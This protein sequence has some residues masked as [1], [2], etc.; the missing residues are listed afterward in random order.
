LKHH[1]GYVTNLNKAVEKLN[2][3]RRAEDTNSINKR[4][5]KKDFFKKLKNSLKIRL[6]T[7][8]VA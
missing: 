6:A 3:A 7:Q 1:Q 4:K 2:A 8:F 5:F